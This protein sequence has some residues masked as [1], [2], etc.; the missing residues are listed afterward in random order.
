[1]TAPFFSAR[2]SVVLLAVRYALPVPVLATIPLV[3]AAPDPPASG[4]HCS[5]RS[6]ALSRIQNQLRYANSE[7]AYLN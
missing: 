3:S 7:F 6:E 4:L 1:M 2:M 5:Q